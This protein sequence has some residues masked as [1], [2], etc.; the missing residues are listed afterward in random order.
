MSIRSGYISFVMN[1]TKLLELNIILELSTRSS[2]LELNT[3]T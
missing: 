2:S 3:R 1:Y